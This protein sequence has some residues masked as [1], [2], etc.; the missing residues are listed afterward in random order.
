MVIAFFF[1]GKLPRFITHTNLVLL[2]KKLVVNN[3][4]DLRLIL[5]SNFITKIFSRIVHER[6]KSIFPDIVSKE[7]ASFVQDKSIAENILVV[8]EI[9]AEIKKKR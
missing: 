8:E 9:V 1:G 4:S 3:F 6:I 5:L 7:Q 2:P